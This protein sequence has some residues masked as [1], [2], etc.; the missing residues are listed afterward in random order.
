[1][2]IE[3]NADVAAR[4]RGVLAEKQVKRGEIAVTLNLSAMSISRRLSGDTPFAPEE[5][6]KIAH[7]CAVPVGTFFGEV[8]QFERAA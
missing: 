2:A 4:V 8:T 5:L 7:Q 1:M 6:I 3:T